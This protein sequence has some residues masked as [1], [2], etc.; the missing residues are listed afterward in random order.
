MRLMPNSDDKLLT[1]VSFDISTA[2]DFILGLTELMRIEPHASSIYE[3]QRAAAQMGSAFVGELQMLFGR[4]LGDNLFI[5]SPYLDQIPHLDIGGLLGVIYQ[6]PS[7]RTVPDFLDFLSDLPAA[8]LLGILASNIDGSAPTTYWP[9][10]IEHIAAGEQLA[11]RDKQLFA[12]YMDELPIAYQ[13]YIQSVLAHPTRMQEDLLRLLRSYYE[14]FFST[15]AE[16]IGP[17]LRRTVRVH[18]SLLGTLPTSELIVQIT[19]GVRVPPETNVPRIIL[20]P[21]YLITPYVY[22]LTLKDALVIIYSALPEQEERRDELILDAAMLQRLKA[23]TDETRLKIL[24]LLM[25]E[26]QRTQ[27]LAKRLDLTPPTISHHLT[28]LRIAGLVQIHM[29]EDMRQVYAVRSEA[30]N[31][32]FTTLHNYLGL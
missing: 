17:R 23:L 16:R 13:E 9:T 6:V 24:R 18:Q 11:R 15:E 7:P 30:V 8:H 4:N 2:Y 21:S 27:D 3:R 31:E 29:T 28:Q 14:Q 12:E 32:L 19:N 25:R 26:P 22:L 20:A 5:Q 10:L 1:R